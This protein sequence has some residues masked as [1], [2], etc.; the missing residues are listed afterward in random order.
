MTNV[1]S[2]IFAWNELNRVAAGLLGTGQRLAKDL[3]GKHCVLL[4]GAATP[5]SLD[6]L[7]YL[8]DSIHLADH[9]CPSNSEGLGLGL[10][11]L[12]VVAEETSR[13]SLPGPFLPTVWAATLLSRLGNPALTSPYLNSIA[14]GKF[15]VTVALLEPETG[16]NPEDVQL[17]LE[18]TNGAWQLIGRK[19]FVLDAE[20]AD[21]I[22]FVV[23]QGQDLAVVAVPRGTPGMTI[24]ATPALDATRK[25]YDVAVQ[26]VLITGAQVLAVGG[27]ASSALE[28]AA[29][30]A[31]VAVCAET[32]GAMQWVLEATVE[33]AK[34]RQQFG[35][36]IGSFQAVQHQCA[37]ML[38]HTESARAATL[39][40]AWALT[41]GAPDASTAVSVAKAFCSDKGRQVCNHGVQVHGGIGFSWEH[42][43]HL[44][45]KRVT[46]CE[47]LFGN[48]SHHREKIARA[49]LDGPAKE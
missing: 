32:V 6:E 10:V 1:S 19:T 5:G 42:D 39:Y 14:E 26:D 37:D 34:T 24:K 29:Q 47:F 40:A 13:A 12:A 33:Y 4:M 20:I 41:A 36:A 46:I 18:K 31:T 28:H 3:N 38:L 2:F 16:W 45:F 9:P 15:K 43:L 25:L 22:L 49:I 11:E 7:S 17:H 27:P 35:Q 21:V 23:R 48:A 44:H 30:V 8:A